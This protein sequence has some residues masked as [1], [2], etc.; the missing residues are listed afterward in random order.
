[1]LDRTM[2]QPARDAVLEETVGHLSRMIQTDTTNPPGNE[3]ALGRYIASVL[4]TAGIEMRLLEPVAGRAAVIGRIRGTGPARPVLLLAHMDVVAAD[5]ADWTM[6]P[7]GG[8]VRDGYLYGRGAIDDKGMLAAN[9]MV[10]LLLQRTVARTGVSLKRDVVFVA[11]ADEEGSGEWGIGWLATHHPDLLSAEFAINEGGRIRVIGGR[12]LYAAVQTAEKV[13]NLVTVTA[14]GSGGHAAIPV[15]D[16]AVALL[17]RAVARIAAHREPFRLLPTTREFFQQLSSVWPNRAEARAMRE[18]GSRDAARSTRAATR[19][20]R[21]PAFGAVLRT[22]ISPT[23][24]AGGR[25]HN[26]IPE[27]ASAMLSIR[28]LPGDSLDDV[29]ERLRRLV[30]DDH[31]EVTIVDRGIDAP[32]SD[33]QSPMFAAIR[34]S[35]AALDPSIVTVPYLSTGATDSAHLR[36][37][38]VQ[39]FGLLPFPLEPADEQR[40]H[41]ADERVP[42]TALVFGVRLL[43]DTLSR[44]AG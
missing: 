18:L 7:F 32:A 19:L 36:A 4:E 34:D 21:V 24:I 2:A 42:L 15:R 37:L 17:C 5:P 43:F 9:L 28:T 29:V 40:M 27:T 31:I 14:H 16:N 6:P 13:S 23:V 3:L 33:Y 12:P 8:E 44:M 35:V 10:M 41:A 1:M 26:V 11:T 39:A 38:G 30:H 22:G 25:A 20:A